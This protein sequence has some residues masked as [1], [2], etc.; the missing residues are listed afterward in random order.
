MMTKNS[1]PCLVQGLNT[2]QMRAQQVFT[3]EQNKVL[4]GKWGT[5]GQSPHGAEISTKINNG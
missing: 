5:C 3:E 2:M 4:A 1:T